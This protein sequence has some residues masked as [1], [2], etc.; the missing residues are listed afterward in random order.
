VA[1]LLLPKKFFKILL[2]SRSS[3]MIF[4]WS[5]SLASQTLPL[6]PSGRL[7]PFGLGSCS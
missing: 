4:E 7:K 5:L 3:P 2:Q 1:S 6:V